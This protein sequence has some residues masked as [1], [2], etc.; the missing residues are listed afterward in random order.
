MS[1]T[2]QHLVPQPAPNDVLTV[3]QQHAAVAA[4]CVKDVQE[5][6]EKQKTVYDAMPQYTESEFL[7]LHSSMYSKLI[8]E[9]IHGKLLPPWWS[10]CLVCIS[11]VAHTTAIDLMAMQIPLMLFANLQRDENHEPCCN[12]DVGPFMIGPCL[13]TERCR[14]TA[15]NMPSIV[16]TAVVG[17]QMEKFESL[18]F[19]GDWSDK[20]KK[21]QH[22]IP[23]KKTKKIPM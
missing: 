20:E 11:T 21:K 12:P 23:K 8:A 3:R 1:S 17:G 2:T 9:L 18:G 13:G 10:K 14:R 22:T 15:S 7:Q 6:A 16:V 5:L 19:G 4:E